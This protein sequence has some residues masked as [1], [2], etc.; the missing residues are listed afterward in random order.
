MSVYLGSVVKEDSILV[1]DIDL[2]LRCDGSE[3]LGRIGGPHDLVEGNPV[4][5][6]FPPFALVEVDRGLRSHTEIIPVEIGI[7]IPLGNVD[8]IACL[9]EGIDS[10]PCDRN[11]VGVHFRRGVV[12]IKPSRR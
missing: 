2:A 7:L 3:D 11:L 4:P 12:G 8:R 10:A 6:I 9:L 5:D 1:E